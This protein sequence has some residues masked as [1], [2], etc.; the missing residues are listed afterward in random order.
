MGIR[1]YTESSTI[2]K[3]TSTT[4]EIETVEFFNAYMVS[5][6]PISQAVSYILKQT[7]FAVMGSIN[8]KSDMYV[9]TCS[10]YQLNEGGVG[11]IWKKL[12]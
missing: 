12:T 2:Y 6:T 3:I 4:Q 5:S 9:F 7:E 1:F 8:I 11:Q 10:P